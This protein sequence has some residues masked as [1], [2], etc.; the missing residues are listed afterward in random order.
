MSNSGE[1]L[2]Q[3]LSH[4]APS[5]RRQAALDDAERIR[6]TQGDRWI[7][8]PRA[9]RAREHLDRLLTTPKRER[10][11]CMVVHG[12]S[13]IGKT[14]ILHKFQREHPPAFDYEV[15]VERRPVISMQMPATPDQH[16]FYSALLFELGAPHSAN[17]RLSVLERLARELLRRM[18]PKMLIVDE[19]HHLLAGSY[20]EQ[21][22][23]LNLVKYLAN[24]LKMSI[25]LAGTSDAMIALNTDAQ[26]RSR[27]ASF[28]IPRWRESEE[29]R[30]LLKAFERVIP[31]RKPSHLDQRLTAQFLLAA[32]DGL[33]G[34]VSRLLNTAAELAIR[35]RSE[36]INL[37]HL[38]HVV[39]RAAA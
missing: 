28:E 27:F 37:G 38:E 18:A 26:M 22:A 14:L 8:Y 3:S 5:T 12:D 31:L 15:G 30:G 39:R 21:R 2:P 29:F 20:Q 32:S 1:S 7:D 4:L 17:A 16:R 13:N 11:P 34:E 10:M 35:D 9:L 36:C 23:S 25:V 33:K 19:V 6:I 24:D